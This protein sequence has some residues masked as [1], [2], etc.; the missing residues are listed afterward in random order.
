MV[1]EY[2]GD[3]LRAEAAMRK[4]LLYKAKVKLA[5]PLREQ[6]WE[7]CYLEFLSK[8][9][10]V[11]LCGFLQQNRPVYMFCINSERVIDATRSGSPAR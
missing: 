11:N 2:M 1:I 6:R 8:C 7:K 5:Q 9:I 3:I 10:C 4:E